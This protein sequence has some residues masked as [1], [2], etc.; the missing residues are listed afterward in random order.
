MN[1]LQR[2]A[3]NTAALLLADVMA[4]LLGLVFAVWAARYL[5]PDEFGVLTFA[6]AF[7]TLFSVLADLGMG[8]L[9]IREVAR[10][11]LLAA[12]Y[13]GTTLALKL[14]LACVV[15]GVIAFT[16]NALDYP[17]TTIL[18]VYIITG[19]VL[20]SS[21]ASIGVSVFQAFE[22]MEYVLVG[23]VLSGIVKVAALYLVMRCGFGLF[24]VAISYTLS[25]LS[26]L[27]FTGFTVARR[28]SKIR[29]HVDLTFMRRMI[30]QALPF[31]LSLI[32]IT[33]YYKI[34]SVMLSLFHDETT[35]GLYN[36]A[37][38]LVLAPAFIPRA[39]LGSLY[40][41]MSR[42]FHYSRKSLI[43]AYERSFKYL[44]MLAAPLAMG[45]TILSSRLILAIYGPEY[46]AAIIILQ[47]LIW[48]E[49]FVFLNVVFGNLFASVDKQSVV[50]K[51]TAAAAMLNVI[52]NAMVI[53]R[54]SYIGAAATTVATECF[55]FAFLF[56]QSHRHGF[57]LPKRLFVQFG[58]RVVLSTIAMSGVIFAFR[59]LSL[60]AI[61]P[62]AVVVYFV[63]LWG[64]GGLDTSD[65]L[66]LLQLFSRSRRR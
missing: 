28:F 4:R 63:V 34:D 40:P 30:I 22:K 27:L 10:N 3:K 41:T 1:T 60:A 64:V 12:R 9:T 18:I 55:A 5:G 31:G 2:I 61:I 35:V 51:Q 29:V 20:L 17:R 19:H 6:V 14:V 24:G 7:C 42:C 37:Y 58:P 15:G 52:L 54:Y 66:L 49:F 50:L 16:V 26:L 57:A 36:A 39:L 11:K 59:N 33:I 23:Q 32:S 48:S 62:I 38:T 25:A 56:W 13:V 44:L 46:R 47:I 65:R 8:Q 43:N 21:F 53:P 45:T